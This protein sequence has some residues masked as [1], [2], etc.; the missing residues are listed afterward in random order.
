MVNPPV[1]PGPGF[2]N[3][4]VVVKRP[5]PGSPDPANHYDISYFFEGQQVQNGAI[6]PT[7]LDVVI[8]YQ[9]IEPTPPE[10]R[11]TGLTKNPERNKVQLSQASVS[12]DGKM[13]T[14]N[15]KCDTREKIDVTLFW[16]DCVH[17]SQ[18]PEVINNP[19]IRG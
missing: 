12:L 7:T 18:D 13:I 16:A 5:P 6:T 2:F 8:N 15:D 14:F 3:I 1:P 19:D 17:F 9:L 11:F 10:I 4:Q